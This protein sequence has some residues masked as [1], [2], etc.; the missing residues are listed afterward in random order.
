[1]ASIFS[2]TSG[3]LRMRW[4]SAENLSTTGLGVAAGRNKPNQPMG[5]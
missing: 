1:M 5:S 2:R 3:N 4:V